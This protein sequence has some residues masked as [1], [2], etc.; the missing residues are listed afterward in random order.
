MPN[1]NKKMSSLI[2]KTGKSEQGF[3][4]AFESQESESIVSGVWTEEFKSILRACAPAEA[5]LE[6]DAKSLI[7]ISDQLKSIQKQQAILHGERVLRAK[8]ILEKYK[9]KAFSFWILI[10]YG[11]RQTP[12]NF[13]YYYTFYSSLSHEIKGL[14]VPGHAP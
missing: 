9:A 5:D 1:L 11:N 7:E 14:V 6:K 8:N 13:L 12:Y 2:D 3:K 4:Q 10:T